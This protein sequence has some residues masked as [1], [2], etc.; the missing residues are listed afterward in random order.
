MLHP[1]PAALF[2]QA[3]HLPGLCG[4]FAGQP[5]AGN[6][7]VA[8]Q[9]GFRH[10]ATS[11]KGQTEIY[12]EREILGDCKWQGRNARK[13][14]LSSMT[15]ERMSQ[16]PALRPVLSFVAASVSPS[17][18]ELDDLQGFSSSWAVCFSLSSLQHTRL[19]VS[20]Y[21]RLYCCTRA[22][23]HILLRMFFH[24]PAANPHVASD[25]PHP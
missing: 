25:L 20:T 8:Q 5:H 17:V 12:W 13:I 11:P 15:R 7:L 9:P 19:H 2:Y 1:L 24:L 10:R 6:I 16:E 21:S 3:R 18:L 4:D 22:H 14:P 23:L